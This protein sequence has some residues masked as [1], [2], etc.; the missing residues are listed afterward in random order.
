MSTWLVSIVITTKN[1]EKNIENCLKSISNQTYWSFEIIVVDNFSIDKTKEISLRYTQKV[2]DKWPER[3]AQRNYGMR[4]MSEGEYVMY[5]DA[6]MILTPD[7]VEKSIKYMQAWNYDA[8][9]ISEVI[10]W[11]MFWSQVRR[12]ERSFYDWTVVDSCRIFKKDFFEKI[13]GFDESMSGPEDWD[14]DKKG[15]LNWKIGM[16]NP[17]N[18]LFD[19]KNWIMYDF[20]KQRWVDPIN[21]GSVVYHNE[22]EFDLG[23]Y[24]TKK[25]YYAKSFDTY[26]KKWWKNDEDIKKQLWLIY[27]FFLIFLEKGKWKNLLLHPVLTFWMYFLRFLVGIKFIFRKN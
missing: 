9:Y 25:W 24:L 23:K 26:I 20:I 5:I 18:P 3:S 6:D 17:S 2:F 22:S 13:W 27:R 10:L 12:F 16:L 8:L 15:R 21:Y 1:E 14:I 7:L 4:D 11:K 19:Q